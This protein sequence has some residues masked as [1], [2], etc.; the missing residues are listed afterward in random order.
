MAERTPRSQNG[1]EGRK[2]MSVTPIYT[3]VR[4]KVLDSHYLSAVLGQSSQGIVL[5]QPNP[6]VEF[7]AAAI[8]GRRPVR[9]RLQEIPCLAQEWQMSSCRPEED[10][11]VCVVV[12]VVQGDNLVKELLRELAGNRI[13]GQMEQTHV[14]LG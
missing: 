2:T 1:A 12:H 7:E 3:K 8:W 11:L 4:L 13:R 6:K 9:L 5:G 14:M 10:F